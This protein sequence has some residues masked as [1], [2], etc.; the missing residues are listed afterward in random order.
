MIKIKEKSLLDWDENQLGEDHGLKIVIISNVFD[1]KV[2][3]DAKFFEELEADIVQE[4][5]ESVG[6]IQKFELFRE[7]PEGT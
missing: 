2:E 7:H 5:Q 4:I 3:H 1:S 6:D